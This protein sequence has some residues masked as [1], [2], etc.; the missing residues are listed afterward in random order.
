MEKIYIIFR[1]CVATALCFP[2]SPFR[3]VCL[4]MGIALLK[5]NFFHGVLLSVRRKQV[6][7]NVAFTLTRKENPDKLQC[8]GDY[9]F[10]HPRE[11]STQR[12]I[13]IR[14]LVERFVLFPQRKESHN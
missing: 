6:A 11:L 3:T 7:G 4:T 9:F 5:C 2:L 13:V 1:I 10:K 14:Q 12:N 8:D